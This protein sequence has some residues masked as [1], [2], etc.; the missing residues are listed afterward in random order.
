[1]SITKKHKKLKLQWYVDVDMAFFYK[2]A[3][4]SYGL[5][6]TKKKSFGNSW[7]VHIEWSNHYSHLLK[8]IESQ[9]LNS[10]ETFRNVRIDN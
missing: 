8:N 9:N 7:Y 2:Q 4:K 1:M 3:I 6:I 10:G 5:L